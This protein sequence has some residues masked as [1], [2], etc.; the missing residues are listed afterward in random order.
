MCF[1]QHCKGMKF[2]FF[3]F[4]NIYGFGST[5]KFAL[6]FFP[7]NLTCLRKHLYH[8]SNLISLKVTHAFILLWMQLLSWTEAYAE[9]LNVN[10]GLQKIVKQVAASENTSW[11]FLCFRVCYVETTL[12][13]S[14]IRLILIFIMFTIILRTLKHS[15]QVQFK[16]PARTG[17]VLPFLPW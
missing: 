3:S 16:K 6:Y 1:P 15:Y 12:K 5:L 4:L 10:S 2:V 11:K 17:K 8:A 9:N 7:W 14:C 13:F